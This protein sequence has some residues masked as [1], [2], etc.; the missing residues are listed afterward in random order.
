M[1]LGAF[2]LLGF[3]GEIFKRANSFH[4]FHDFDEPKTLASQAF[5]PLQPPIQYIDLC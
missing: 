2:L 3:A 4:N 5:S 1:T